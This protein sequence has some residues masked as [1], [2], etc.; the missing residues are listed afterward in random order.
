MDTIPNDVFHLI[1]WQLPPAD[2][3]ELFRTNRRASRCPIICQKIRDFLTRKKIEQEDWDTL[4]RIYPH[5]S[6]LRPSYESSVFDKFTYHPQ[7]VHYKEVLITLDKTQLMYLLGTHYEKYVDAVGR[8]AYDELS[9]FIRYQ[10]SIN[11][12]WNANYKNFKPYVEQCVWRRIVDGRYRRLLLS[13]CIQRLV[14]HSTIWQTQ[15]R[16]IVDS[17]FFLY[18]KEH[19][20]C[21]HCFEDCLSRTF[22][23][24]RC[25]PSRL[26]WLCKTRPS[27]FNDLGLHQLQWY[28]LTLEYE[29]R[30]RLIEKDPVLKER[31]VKAVSTS[32]VKVLHS[33]EKLARL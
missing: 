11:K 4:I 10:N 24:K 28:M 33:S 22:I 17:E 2:L 14:K 12:P 19:L 23:C 25:N 26:I 18:L 15:E 21:N 7:Q 1:A 13:F 8:V 20:T 5:D 31:I 16:H 3:R 29:K 27:W 9:K 30:Q 6:S 32:M